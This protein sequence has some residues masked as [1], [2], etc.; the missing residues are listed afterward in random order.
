MEDRLAVLD[1]DDAAGGEG[2]AVANAVDGVDDGRAGVAGA[3]E[4]RVQG[5]RRAVLGD[6]APGGDQ[7]LG[8]DLAAEDPGHDGRAAG[9][10]EDVLLDALQVE[11]FEQG[12]KGVVHARTAF[13]RAAARG[14]GRRRGSGAQQGARSFTAPW[15]WR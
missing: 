15:T 8:R 13:V 6:G 14:A 2:A 3:Q 12:E 5:V 7:G 11:L 10:A 1:G 4:V 9:A